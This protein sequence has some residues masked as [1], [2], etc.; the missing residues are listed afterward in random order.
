MQDGC[1]N[2]NNVTTFY[3]Q[4]FKNEK[5]LHWI[6]GLIKDKHVQWIQDS[7]NLFLVIGFLSLSDKLQISGACTMKQTPQNSHEGMYVL[8]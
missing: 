7:L 8:L 3:A 1:I 6:F 2:K 5:H 4:E